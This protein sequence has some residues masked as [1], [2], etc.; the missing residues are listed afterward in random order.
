MA[1]ALYPALDADASGVV[2]L[3]GEGQEVCSHP[4]CN[5]IEVKDFPLRTGIDSVTCFG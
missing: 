1:V 3:K 2:L 5:C 4:C